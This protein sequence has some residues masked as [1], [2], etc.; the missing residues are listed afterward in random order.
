MIANFIARYASIY[1]IAVY[2]VGLV[3][4]IAGIWGIKH[5]KLTLMH[6]T[7]IEYTGKMAIILSIIFILGGIYFLIGGIN[8]WDMRSS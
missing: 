1:Q 8:N 3:L 6:N 7:K 5:R 2:V 4:I